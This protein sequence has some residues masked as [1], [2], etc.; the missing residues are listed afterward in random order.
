MD[1]AT[2][3]TEVDPD[4]APGT[5][6]QADRLAVALDLT[7]AGLELRLQRHRREHP[8]ATPEELDAVAREWWSDRS[9]APDGDASGP[10][11][12]RRR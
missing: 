4:A 12:V 9:G 1:R 6:P 3:S 7:Q 5:I 2:S 11:R 8:D 10:F